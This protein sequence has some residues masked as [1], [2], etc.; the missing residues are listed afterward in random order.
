MTRGL[1]LGLV[2]L[3]GLALFFPGQTEAALSIQPAYVQL[4]LDRGR[5]SETIAVTNLLDKDARYRIHV[6]HFIYGKNGGL[7][8]VPPDEHSLAPWTKINPR[9]F[10]LPAKGRR[11]IRLSVI[12]P[13]NL[14][15]GEYWGTIELEPLEGSFTEA[16][17]P[18]GRTM[19]L[20]IVTS[21]LVPIVGEVG[22]IQHSFEMEDL[23]AW[24]TQEGI[25]ITAHLVNT[26]TGRLHPMGAF[27]VLNASG[28]IISEGLIGDDTILAGGERIFSRV[29]KGD[30]PDPSYA[31]RVRYSAK[32]LEESVA[33]QTR[34][35]LRGPG[36]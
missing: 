23:S 3:I 25:A 13:K 32:R 33:G 22:E 10:T 8:Q 2:A 9:E 24:K 16:Q 31:V 19:R 14:P 27:E 30:F 1:G 26:G 36:Q 18:D 12:P 7:Q 28:D 20:E 4:R 34:V 35:T 5:P 6:R 15:P 29:V 11:I 17:D 21:I